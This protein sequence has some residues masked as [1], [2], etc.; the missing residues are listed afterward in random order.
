[1][2]AAAIAGGT[3]HLLDVVRE[4]VEAGVPL[5]DAVRAASWTPAGVLGLDDRG[6]LVAGRRADVVVTDADL[7]VREVLRAGDPVDLDL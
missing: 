7:R 5:V 1:M 4:T 2:P 6:G 3:Y